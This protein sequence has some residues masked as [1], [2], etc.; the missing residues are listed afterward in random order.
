[1]RVDDDEYITLCG[2][3][4]SESFE[5]R[6][7]KLQCAPH[8]SGICL[9]RISLWAHALPLSGSLALAPTGNRLA[10]HAGQTDKQHNTKKQSAKLTLS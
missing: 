9:F 3:T 6:M 8:N 2:R 5:F 4:I 7:N 1:M 10:E